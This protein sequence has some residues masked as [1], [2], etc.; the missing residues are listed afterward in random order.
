MENFR[1]MYFNSM[2]KRF[3]QVL[4]FFKIIL[5]KYKI[6]YLTMLFNYVFL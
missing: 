5:E 4:A 1:N 2:K 6:I 3:F